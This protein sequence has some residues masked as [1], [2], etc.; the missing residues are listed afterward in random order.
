MTSKRKPFHEAKY[1]EENG[2]FCPILEVLIGK[3]EH[4]IFAYANTGCTTGLSLFKKR[5]EGIDI[6]TKISDEPSPCIMAD[7]HIG[8]CH[9][10]HL[11]FLIF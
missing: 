1:K 10:Y 2:E 5:A 3:N 4:G 8:Y 6:G 11:S 7:G 9:L